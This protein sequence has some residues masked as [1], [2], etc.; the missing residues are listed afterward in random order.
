[1]T[2]EEQNQAMKIWFE[3]NKKNKMNLKHW[4]KCI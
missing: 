4:Q 3:E 1:M 2:T